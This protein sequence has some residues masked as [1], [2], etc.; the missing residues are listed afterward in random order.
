MTDEEFNIAGYK[1]LADQESKR[2]DEAIKKNFEIFA[3]GFAGG[4]AIASAIWVLF[5]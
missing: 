4:A 3:V 2:A 1:Y 5:I